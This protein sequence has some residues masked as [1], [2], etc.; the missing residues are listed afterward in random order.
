MSFTAFH[1]VSHKYLTFFYRHS[2]PC[3]RRITARLLLLVLLAA[4]LLLLVVLVGCYNPSP[5]PM[6]RHFSRNEK[7]NKNRQPLVLPPKRVPSQESVF[8]LSILSFYSVFSDYTQFVLSFASFYS[9]LY[10]VCSQ[11]CLFV[12]SFF[13]ETEYTQFKTEYTRFKN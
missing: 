3:Y 4:C 6:G 2:Y 13:R 1:S 12:L 11:F 10:S 8:K 9:V 5:R 7:S